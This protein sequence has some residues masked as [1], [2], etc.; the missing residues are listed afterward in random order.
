MCAIGAVRVDN[1]VINGVIS[2]VINVVISGFCQNVT[3]DPGLGAIFR[4]T[5][6][7][8]ENSDF[9]ENSGYL[10]ENSGLLPVY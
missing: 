7:F 9:P 1:V 2:G 5:V 4:K 6:S 10:P 8:D 3:F